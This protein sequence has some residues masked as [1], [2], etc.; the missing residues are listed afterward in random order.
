MRSVAVPGHSGS[1]PQESCPQFQPMLIAE[2]L[3]PG[4]GALRR[5]RFF[6]TRPDSERRVPSR[7]ERILFQSAETVFGAP[8]KRQIMPPPIFE[9]QLRTVWLEF[10]V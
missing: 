8:F 5:Q 2:M 1:R 6:K 9:C 4:T 3:C 10:P 7:L